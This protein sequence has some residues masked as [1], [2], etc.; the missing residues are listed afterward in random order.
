LYWSEYFSYWIYLF[1]LFLNHLCLLVKI[2]FLIFNQ[3]LRRARMF[4][5]TTDCS[6]VFAFFSI[7]NAYSR[8]V[9]PAL[10][11]WDWS[12]PAYT[13]NFT[14]NK[15]WLRTDRIRSVLCFAGVVILL[16]ERSSL[17]IFRTWF[18]SPFLAAVNTFSKGFLLIV[19]SLAS[20]P[21]EF[22]IYSN[23]SK[24][25]S[26]NNKYFIHGIWSKSC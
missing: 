19:K 25:L 21:L 17:T 6:F 22:F 9:F 16:K 23:L 20:F 8:A 14:I 18:T 15:C 10:S 4:L 12:T 1:I 24:S 7:Y 3:F 11:L 5:E 2:N 26:K 13:K